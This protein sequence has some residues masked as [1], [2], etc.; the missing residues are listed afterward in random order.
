MQYVCQEV[1][2]LVICDIPQPAVGASQ[3]THN[4]MIY[5]DA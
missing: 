2:I 3:A 5:V 4:L 1:I